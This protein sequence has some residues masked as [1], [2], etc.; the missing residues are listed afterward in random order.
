MGRTR[1]G[2]VEANLDAQALPSGLQERLL[3]EAAKEPDVNE[4]SVSRRLER[5]ALALM[6]VV[7][8]G[9]LIG[10]GYGLYW[11]GQL[12]PFNPGGGG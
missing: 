12:L 6:V 1:G 10:L 7:Q 11:V 5:A 8:L 2:R 9:W 4:L 3:D